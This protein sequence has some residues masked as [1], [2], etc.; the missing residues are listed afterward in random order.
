[1]LL[2]FFALL[3]FSLFFCLLFSLFFFSSFGL[4]LFPLSL[5]F[6]FNFL[7]LCSLFLG[8]FFNFLNI[9][10]LFQ[11]VSRA[12]QGAVDAKDDDEE[13]ADRGHG[14]YLRLYIYNPRLSFSLPHII[15]RNVLDTSSPPPS[16]Q[17]SC[18]WRRRNKD[19]SEALNY[20][21]LSRPFMT[22]I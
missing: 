18:L 16:P 22:L 10:S 8:V 9:F 11:P 21:L 15:K 6:R 12:G 3:G 13:C 17:A 7:N 1:M 4:T 2:V 5:S 20:S 14:H 19:T